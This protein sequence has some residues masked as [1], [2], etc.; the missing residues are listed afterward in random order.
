MFLKLINGKHYIDGCGLVK[1]RCICYA[2]S[3]HHSF[4]YISSFVFQADLLFLSEVQ[5]LHDITALVSGWVAKTL[6]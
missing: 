2:L 4:A 3:V 1:N 6:S 5:V